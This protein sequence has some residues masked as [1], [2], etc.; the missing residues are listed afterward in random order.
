MPFVVTSNQWEY[1][2]HATPVLFSKLSNHE[3]FKFGNCQLHQLWEVVGGFHCVGFFPQR[4]QDWK[5]MFWKLESHCLSENV[6]HLVSEIMSCCYVIT[7]PYAHNL[8]TCWFDVR[9][10][11]CARKHCIHDCSM[12]SIWISFWST[13]CF[14][15]ALTIPRM[16]R[17]LLAV[18]RECIAVQRHVWMFILADSSTEIVFLDHIKPHLTWTE[19]HLLLLLLSNVNKI[20]VYC[21]AT[22]VTFRQTFKSVEVKCKIQRFKKNQSHVCPSINTRQWQAFVMKLLASK[23]INTHIFPNITKTQKHL[24]KLLL[25]VSY[26][27]YNILVCYHSIAHRLPV[28]DC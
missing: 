15:Y 6:F 14:S 20:F 22:F 1:L 16:G 13:S 21:A 9:L 10:L 19:T 3:Q 7:G 27:L 4:T 28:N 24:D 18:R 8:K 2:R 17:T 5:R 11:L 26:R 23:K 12:C 25:K